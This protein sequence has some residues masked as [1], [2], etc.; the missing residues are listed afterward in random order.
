MLDLASAILCSVSAI[1][2]LSNSVLMLLASLSR[3]RPLEINHSGVQPKVR[4]AIVVPAYREGPFIHYVIQSLKE[5]DYPKD[6]LKLVIVGEEDDVETYREVAKLCDIR[7]EYL[8]C[9][10]VKGVYLVNKSRARGKPAALNFAL[11]YVNA[12]VI[13][14]YDAEDSIHPKHVSIAV[15]L[16]KDSSVAAVQFVREVA[17]IPGALGE[18]QA[19]DFHFYYMVLQPFLMRYTGLAEICGSAFFIKSSLIKEVGGFNI[20]SPAEDLDL[21]YRLGALGLRILLALPPSTTRPIANTSSLIKQRA[22]WIRGGI[23]SIPTGLSAA[24]RSI[25]L[26][27]VTGFMPITTVT[28]S[29]A[30]LLG[31]VVLLMGST[32]TLSKYA[33]VALVLACVLGA[34]S[35]L[36]SNLGATRMLKYLAVMSIVYYLA[37]WR[38]LVELFTSP[39]SWTKSQSKA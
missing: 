4:V 2:V 26:V 11:K 24:P 22:R 28:S 25:P 36:V 18:A 29:L 15:E 13:G 32:V 16:L 8:D 5:V 10:G 19:A 21:T 33:I 30:L 12:D 20:N 34:S 38:A 9:G 35:V 7:D 23:L 1:I 37:S 27:L 39:R 31:V 6:Y 17:R 3:S 14:F